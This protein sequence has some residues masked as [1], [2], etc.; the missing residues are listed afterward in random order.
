MSRSQTITFSPTLSSVYTTEYSKKG[1]RA[2]LNRFVA[3][4]LNNLAID[5]AK[6][7][8]EYI[9]ALAEIKQ[10]TKDDKE[11]FF[12]N[13]KSNFDNIFPSSE[14]DHKYVVDKINKISGA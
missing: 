13:L 9:E 10:I 11:I 12:A 6:G 7:S 14:V 8:G 2:S 3:D 5:I 4:N 1:S